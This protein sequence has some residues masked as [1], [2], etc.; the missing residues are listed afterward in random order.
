M[1]KNAIHR[2]FSRFVKIKPDELKISFYLFFY[3]FLVIAAYNVVKPIRNASFLAELGYMQLPFVYLLTAVIIGFVVALHSR[4]QVKFS[5][6]YLITISILFFLVSCLVFRVFSG[7]GWKGLPVIFWVWANVFII[8]LNTQFWILVNDI[9]NPREFKRLSGFFISGGILGGFIGGV[10]AGVL[11]KENVDYNLLFISAG[12]LFLCSLFVYLIFRWQKKEERAETT[13][14]QREIERSET[15]SRP[16]FRDC[17]NTVKNHSY[18]RFIATIVVLTLIVSTLIDFQFQTIVQNSEKTGNLT[19]FFGFFNAGLMIFAFLLSILMTSKLYENYGVRIS[20]LLYPLVLLLCFL[21]IGIAATLVMAIIIKGSDKSLSYS[22]NRSARELL[23]IPISPDI[24][25]KAIIFIDMFVDRFSKG[26]GAVVLLII[27]SFGIQDY[28][29]LVKIVSLVSVVLILGWIVFTLRASKEY[30]GWIIKNLL[31]TEPRPDK[32]LE[33]GLDMDYVKLIID[34]LESKDRSPNLYAM[35]LF[36]LMQKGK[37]TPDLMQLLGE[38]PEITA[39]NSLGAFFE[40]D[41]TALIQMKGV[42]EDEYALQK[43]I[44]EI[45]SIDAYGDVMMEYW[46]K[47]LSEKKSDTETAKMEIA[48]VIGFMSADSPMVDKLEE[49]IMDDSSEVRKLAIESMSK[50]RRKEHVPT[51]IQSL[52]DIQTHNDSSAALEKYGSKIT[53]M[54]ADYLGD[55]DENAELRKAVA[56]ILAHIGNQEA[57]DFILWELEKNNRE[58]DTELIDA[59]DRIRSENPSIKFSVQTVK[60][61]IKIEIMS[62]YDLFV[63]FV[64]AE[65][66]EQE[67][68]ICGIMSHQLNVSMMNIFKLLG[69][70]YPH[71]EIVKAFQ[72]IQA[73][74]KKSVAYAVEAL[75]NTLEKEMREAI[76]PMVEDLTLD[77]KV[78]ACLILRKDFPEI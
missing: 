66:K 53:G 12:M 65:S 51:L 21:G 17:F 2:I 76:L 41:P 46:E 38:E 18:L 24:K 58:M 74:T 71:G 68:K 34:T 78:K 75:D 62:Y 28:T 59:L 13:T 69:L 77:E 63:K 1:A 30:R 54:L 44:K 9:L 19:S 50:I 60:N 10:L 64:D 48:K 11:A 26:I 4:L 39:P 52:E 16:G 42:Q 73:G 35:N 29:E 6:H 61:K 3:L 7:F 15:T 33:D 45:M 25:Y 37:L 57:S 47:I 49:L 70:I 23:Y 67:P 20:L 8:V 22:I 5:R 14:K 36:E 72:N 27:M 43:E 31:P 40:S 56:P 55:T 32:S